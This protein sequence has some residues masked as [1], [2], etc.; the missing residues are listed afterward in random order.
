MLKH[1]AKRFA[2]KMYARNENF[3]INIFPFR[4]LLKCNDHIESVSIET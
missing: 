1:V 2:I 3:Q 4:S